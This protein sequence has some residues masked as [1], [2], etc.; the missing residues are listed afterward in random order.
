V[1]L[2][3]QITFRNMQASEDIEAIIHNRAEKLNQYFGKIMRCRVIIEAHHKY[4]QQGNVYDVHI[5]MITPDIQIAIS[6]VAALNH[7]YEDVD[8]A[9]REAFDAA[10][11]Q[12]QER[13]KKMPGHVNVHQ[14]SLHGAILELDPYEN[15]GSIPTSGLHNKLH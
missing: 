15:S 6:R 2:P 12:L 13:N 7:A 11:N 14:P 5:D 4:H 8:V 1:K 10:K 9:I 3:L